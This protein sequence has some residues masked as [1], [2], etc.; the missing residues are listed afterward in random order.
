MTRTTPPRPVDI[1]EVLPQLAPLARPATRLHPRPGSPTARDS[2]AGGPLLWPAGEPWPHCDCPHVQDDA[3]P[4][5][6]PQDVR[7]LRQIMAASASRGN[8][9]FMPEE[10]AIMTRIDAGR[11]LPEGPVPMLPVAQLHTRDIP[12]L[13]PPGKA[14]LLQVLWCPFDYGPYDAYPKLALYWRSAD[15]ITDILAHSPEPPAVQRDGYLLEPCLLH[16]EQV[17]E[18]PNFMDLSHDQQELVEQWCRR[19]VDNAGP[20]SPY[21]IDPKMFYWDELSV[22]PG[23]KVGGWPGWGDTDPIPQSC[24]ACGTSMQPL[25]AIAST[26]WDKNT[27]GWIPYEDHA[28]A[29]ARFVGAP[30]PARPTMVQIADDNRLQIYTCPASPDHPHTELIQ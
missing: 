8:S 9:A 29:I 12:A 17:T 14:D 3:N 5:M 16:P 20:G 28:P 7:Q 21:T 18:Y 2:S 6:S 10:S 26:E 23:W 1:G 24:P 25:L 4:L 19:Q 30:H 11:P 22:A 27:R 13:R 15:T